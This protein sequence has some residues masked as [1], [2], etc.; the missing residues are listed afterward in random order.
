RG[1]IREVKDGQYDA[2]PSATYHLEVVDSRGRRIVGREGAL[3]AFGTFHAEVAL[4]ASAPLGTYRIRV[5]QPG[6]SEFAGSFEVQA[7]RLAK[8]E[9]TVELARP[10]VSRGEPVSGRAAARYPDGTPMADR[11]LEVRLPDGRTL[12]GRTGSDGRFAFTLPTEGFAEAQP[13]RIV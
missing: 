9:L 4:D 7:Y 13:L 10:V 3:S 12:R 1:I 6:R 5:Y 2:R 8:A 11:P